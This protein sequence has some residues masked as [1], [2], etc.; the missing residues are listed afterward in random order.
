[1]AELRGPLAGV[2]C[3]AC[4]MFQAGP[5]CFAHFA[6]LGADVIKIEHPVRGV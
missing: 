6:D 1:M 4:T 5:V 2:K 3:V